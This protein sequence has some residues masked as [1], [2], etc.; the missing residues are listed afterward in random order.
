MTLKRG[1]DPARSAP[2]ETET[3][4]ET[5]SHVDC[6][7]RI[8]RIIALSATQNQMPA[9][10]PENN[11]RRSSPT[12]PHAQPIIIISILV[13]ICDTHLYALDA[14]LLSETRKD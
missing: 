3:K 4:D 14:T 1:A 2:H 5:Q 12:P 8:F 9:P 6:F 10:P 11:K 13:E 7:L